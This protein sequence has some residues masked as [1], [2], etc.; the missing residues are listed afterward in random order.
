MLRRPARFA[1]L[2]GLIAVGLVLIAYLWPAGDPPTALP[3]D[4]EWVGD[5]GYATLADGRLVRLRLEGDSVRTDTLADGL[6]FPRGLA[7]TDD[8]IYVAELGELPCSEPI[9]RCKGEHVGPTMIDGE[10]S[11]LASSAGRILVYSLTDGG[12]GDPRVLLDDLP[13]VNTDHG[14][15]DLEL[16]PDGMLYLSIGNLD[17]LAWDDVTDLPDG[18]EMDLL[19]TV[20]KIDPVSGAFAVVASGFRNV[21]GLSFDED[22][23]LWGVD[24]DGRGRGQGWRFEEL[25]RIEEGLDFGFPDDGTVGPYE[26]RTGFATWIMPSGAGSAG[27]LVRDGTVI[28][29]GCGS[30]TR[31][32]LEPD[33]GDAD[34]RT[35]DQRGCVTAVAPLPDG[36]LLLG[37]VLGGQAFTVTSESALFGD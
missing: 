29:G 26:R 4:I 36:R 18:P 9:P 22:G 2:I 1:L 7:V 17:R 6:A 24:N 31:L 30:I 14:L 28:S 8:A 27:L 5:V 32:R 37:T 33:G 19:G 16:G 12:V 35:V 20:L 23:A 3:M 11:L 13:F 25:D 10:R 21:Y 34:L 15:N